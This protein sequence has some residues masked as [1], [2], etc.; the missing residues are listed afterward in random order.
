MAQ[1]R[2]SYNKFVSQKT[3]KYSFEMVCGHHS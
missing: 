3:D 1:A 2:I